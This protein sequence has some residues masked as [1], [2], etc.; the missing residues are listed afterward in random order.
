M[1]NDDHWKR[2]AYLFCV[3][4]YGKNAGA[5]KKWLGRHYLKLHSDVQEFKSRNP[6]TSEE[7]CCTELCRGDGYGPFKVKNAKTLRRVL[8][9]A[10]AFKDAIDQ[11]IK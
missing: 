9:Q 3:A 7:K 6:G 4:I 8:Q 2:L 1:H 10:K 11:G 5:P